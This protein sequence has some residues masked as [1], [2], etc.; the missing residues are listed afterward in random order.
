MAVFGLSLWEQC[1]DIAAKAGVAGLAL[2]L[3]AVVVGGAVELASAYAEGQELEKAAKKAARA[4][5]RAAKQ[6]RYAA[7]AAGQQPRRAHV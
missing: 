2:G 6:Q 3:S 1:L 5:R 4:Q 7:A